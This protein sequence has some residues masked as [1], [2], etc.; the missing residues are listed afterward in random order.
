MTLVLLSRDKGH[1][2]LILLIVLMLLPELLLVPLLDLSFLGVEVVG[3]LEWLEFALLLWPVVG[4]RVE[5]L[6]GVG[7][8]SFLC[9]A[10]LSKG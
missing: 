6:D 3:S 10:S 4:W 8:Q 1:R 9:V 2:A 7:K 5:R